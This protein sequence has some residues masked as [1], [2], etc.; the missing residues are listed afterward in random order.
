M[1]E[2]K[3]KT[4]A[5]DIIIIGDGYT[6][7]IYFEYLR[8]EERLSN[9]KI[10]PELPSG[11]GLPEGGQYSNVFKKAKEALESGYKKIFCLIDMDV[12]Y[13]KKEISAY[14]VA[15]Q[16]YKKKGV[17]ILEMN[18]CFEIWIMLHYKPTNRAF[19]KCDDVLD[20]IKK[21][22]EFKDYNKTQEYHS[23]QN[24][25]KKLKPL[26]E[27]NA[28]PN[29]QFLEIDRAEKSLDYPRSEVFKLFFELGILK[30]G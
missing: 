29:A 25:Y 14:N 22:T 20:L 27:L 10:R 9:F 30:E 21:S 13:S 26:L 19:S 7:K 2:S 12:V 11:S 28:V 16:K 8:A 15:K 3:R 23:K 5:E 4:G 6:E 24:F 17:V 1:R 18:P